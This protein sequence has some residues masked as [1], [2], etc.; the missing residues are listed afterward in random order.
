VPGRVDTVGIVFGPRLSLSAHTFNHLSIEISIRRGP[1]LSDCRAIG[2]VARIGANVSTERTR[3]RVNALTRM[4]VPIRAI[5]PTHN[6]FMVCKSP[7][8]VDPDARAL[9]LAVQRVAPLLEAS[10]CHPVAEGF[11]A[12]RVLATRVGA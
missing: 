11:L 1:T 4:P 9:P 6:L 2:P 5:R 8:Q 12:A 3:A 10:C 7:G